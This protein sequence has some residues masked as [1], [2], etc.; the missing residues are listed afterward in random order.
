M[1]R[2][3][4][5]LLTHLSAVFA[6]MLLMS[7]WIRSSY[8]IGTLRVFDNGT[9]RFYPEKDKLSELIEKGRPCALIDLKKDK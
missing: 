7:C 2:I 9:R 3:A 6:G 5:L 4:V 1:I 8:F